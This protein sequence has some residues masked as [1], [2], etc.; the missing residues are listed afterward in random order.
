MSAINNW[1]RTP[2]GLL[3]DSLT[4]S[5]YACTAAAVQVRNCSWRGMLPKSIRASVR[6]R[7]NQKRVVPDSPPLPL[8]RGR[9]ASEIGIVEEMFGY[10]TVMTIMRPC[11]DQPAGPQVDA[12]QGAVILLSSAAAL[13]NTQ[14]KSVAWS[15]EVATRYTFEGDSGGWSIRC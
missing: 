13:D 15:P 9:A 12:A 8:P 5:V 2:L 14:W 4:P 7:D 1:R 10:G 11:R 6:T 3:S